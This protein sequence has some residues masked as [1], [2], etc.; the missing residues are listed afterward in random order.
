MDQTMVDIT[1]IPG[2]APGDT[3]VVLGKQGD[4]AITAEEL[5]DKTG[6][7]NYEVVCK[8]SACVP[9]VYC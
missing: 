8:F 7:I 6:S 9:R 5:G 2:V 4:E 1:E 3:A